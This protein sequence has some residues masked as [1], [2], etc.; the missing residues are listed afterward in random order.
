VNHQMPTDGDLINFDNEINMR[1]E[2]KHFKWAY[3]TLFHKN[4][5]MIN[6]LFGLF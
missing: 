3:E 2:Q 6:S 4:R 1:F 5:Y